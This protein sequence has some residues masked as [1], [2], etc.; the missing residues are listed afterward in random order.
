MRDLLIEFDNILLAFI[1]N[2]GFKATITY[3][4]WYSF[5]FMYL[6]MNLC[7]NM[8][9]GGGEYKGEGGK[10]VNGGEKFKEVKYEGWGEK[11]RE[12]EYGDEGREYEDME[13]VWRKGPW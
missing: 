11:Y 9:L 6:L 2:N 13:V 4:S 7:F 3:D 1:I 12:G 10:L 5:K 8:E